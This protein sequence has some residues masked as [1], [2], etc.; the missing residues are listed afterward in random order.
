MSSTQDRA[1]GTHDPA[2]H[3]NACVRKITT[4]GSLPRYHRPIGE[5]LDPMKYPVRRFAF[6]VAAYLAFAL[7]LSAQ[8][9]NID[10]Q[11]SVITIHVGKTGLFSGFGHEHEVSAAIRSGTVDTGPRPA[12]EFHVDART[13]RVTDKD[14]SDDDRAK[15]QQT[16]LGPDVLDSEKHPDIVFKSTNAEP[17]G[18]GRRTL[19]G[20]LTI[21]DQTHP[22]TVKVSLKDGHYAG[23][24]NVKQT[25]YGITPP[26]VAGIRAKDELKIEFDVQ[27]AP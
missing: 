21:R 16:M 20:N 17:A 25:D 23:E 15:V 11:K 18:E 7:S 13:L 2:Q 12:V 26:G 1:S 9:H 5:V 14:A 19:R 3:H 22:I 24:A 8:Q 27:L 6:F 10:T 4:R